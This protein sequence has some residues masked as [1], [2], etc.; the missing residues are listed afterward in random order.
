MKTLAVLISILFATNVSGQSI[1][2]QKASSNSTLCLPD[3]T[4]FYVWGGS[5]W[6]LNQKYINTYDANNNLIE[7]IFKTVPSF[8]NSGKNIRTY[9]V[10]NKLL[11]NEWKNWNSSN[12][13]WINN[14]LI[15]YTYNVNSC[16]INDLTETWNTTTNSW[17]LS[18]K[19]TYTYDTNNNLI[20]KLYDEYN[21]AANYWYPSTKITFTYN[22]NND[23]ITQIIEVWDTTNSVWMN[24]NKTNYSYVNN[25]LNTSTQQ[26]WDIN[27]GVWKDITKQTLTYDGN[28]NVIGNLLQ[29]QSPSLTWQNYNRTISNYDPN[30]NKTIEIIESWQNGNWINDYKYQHYAGCLLFPVN[31]TEKMSGNK[32]VMIYPNPVSSTVFIKTDL[33]YKSVKVMDATGKIISFVEQE[34]SISISELNNGIYSIQLIDENGS[35]IANKVIIKSN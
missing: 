13:T 28:N 34:K 25:Y 24:N 26:S 31:L 14:S 27:N 4:F 5:Y 22:L 12:S 19:N 16:A 10:A 9:N 15:S 30:N 7:Q 21:T 6:S 3:S 11:T 35:I 2:A 1:P 18:S 17:Y 29:V 23:L 8:V 20:L 33:N 32:H